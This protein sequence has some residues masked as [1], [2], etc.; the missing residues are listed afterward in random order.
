MF[1][2]TDPQLKLFG[3]HTSV[4][5]SLHRRL[6]ASWASVFRTE[7]L[8]ILLRSEQKFSTL[9]GATGRPNYSVGRVLGI[10]VLQEWHDLAD[11]QA[12]DAYGFDLRWRHALDVTEQEAYLSRRSL[13][14]FRRRLVC[15]DPEMKLIHDIFIEIGKTAIDKLGISTSQQRLDSTHIVSNIRYRGRLALFQDAIHLF[16]KRLSDFEYKQVPEPIRQWHEAQSEGWFGLGENERKA[17][18]VE[19]ARYTHTLIELFSDYKAV[20]A[21]DHYRLIVRLFN[22][23]CELKAE[24]EHDPEIKKNDH[25]QKNEQIDD[26]KPEKPFSDTEA[27]HNDDEIAL[28]KKVEGGTLQSAFDMD[29]SYGHK[30]MGYSA[31]ITETCNN[32]NKPEIITDYEVHGAHRSD[33]GKSD[34]VLDRL[35][36]VR[37]APETLFADGGYPTG[38]SALHAQQRGVELISP[39]N[40][41][42]ID[43]GV[44]SREHFRFSDDNRVICCP[45]GHAPIDHRTLSNGAEL[46]PH[47]I[48]DG[49]ICRQCAKLEQCPVRAPNHRQRGCG[50][51]ETV[52]NFRLE[53]TP[54]LRLRDAMFE[55][56]KTRQWKD[57][58]KIRSGIEATMSELKR[59]GLGKLRVR[60]LIKTTFVVACKVIA[61]NIK[62]WWKALAFP[63]GNPRRGADNAADCVFSAF[64]GLIF[65]LIVPIWLSISYRRCHICIA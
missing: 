3:V 42:R 52:G 13:V 2:E 28:K 62:R 57:L 5:D 30:G 46:S 10:C 6:S 19:L 27:Q 34:D 48:F 39:V 18:L 17:R 29:A 4:G 22:E 50:S 63:A 38:S 51:R 47:V 32:A 49:D 43:D 45:S 31:H 16:L 61:C 9:Y 59:L 20:K 44:M 8:P 33:M 40:R 35:E 11:Q 60:G 7:V 54:E 53:I 26:D 37:L 36:Q 64:V 56:Q 1:K 65:A 12:L 23:Q 15:K 55:L 41:T 14:E 24:H 25:D 58:Y 21:S